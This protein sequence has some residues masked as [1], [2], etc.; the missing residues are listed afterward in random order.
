MARFGLT[1]SDRATEYQPAPAALPIEVDL[2]VAGAGCGGMVAALTASAKGLDVVV[3]EKSGQ[4]GGTT[5]YSAGTAWIPGTD[6]AAGSG[7][8]L[9]AAK[10]YLDTVVGTED[11]ADHRAA[12]LATG[13][14]AVR[15]IDANSL[16]RF[17]CPAHAPD[18]R[19]GPGS[20]TGGRALVAQAFDGRLLGRDMDLVRPPRDGFTVLGGMMVG[21]AD[22]EALLHPFRSV[23]S[24]R[25]V[26]AI[27]LRYA[28]D[29]LSHPRGTRLVM[30]NALVARLLAS[31]RA[32]NVKLLLR[33]GITELLR[34]G[35]RVTGAVLTDANGVST[36]VMARNGVVLA[37]GGFSGAA[38]LRSALLP[39]PA[40][41]FTVAH[42]GNDGDGLRAAMDQGARIGAAGHRSGAFWMP[43]SIRQTGDRRT[44]FPHIILDRAKPGIIAV[45]A[46][47]RRFVNEANSYHD[48]V[49]AMLAASVQPAWLVCDAVALQRYGIGLVHP[50]ARSLRG[51]LRDGYLHRHATLRALATAIGVDAAGLEATAERCC[52]FA[53]GGIDLDFGRGQTALNIQNG[54]PAVRPN[55]CLG[56]VRTPP[57]YAVAVWPADLATSA[58]LATTVDGAVLDQQG[59]PIAGLYAVGNDMESIMRGTYPGPGTT[60]GPAIVF[61]YRAAMHAASLRATANQVE[62]SHAT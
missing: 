27:L 2:L 32:R 51:F 56:P 37:T 55:P 53:R 14:E 21:R 42:A 54:D 36:R 26:A 22:I 62:S 30:G 34:D 16:V 9:A 4:V 61:G 8:S 11:G 17:V 3:V 52:E 7:D 50:G 23:S 43:T 47:G 44:L 13:A 19:E 33:T 40:P 57:F 6:Y 15:F 58:G 28:R 39:H 60:I 48:F 29:R 59:R 10:T 31:L 24:F 45:D 38:D 5:A 18:Y 20:V 35:E 41:E 12:F 1:R 25:H 46:M 49:S